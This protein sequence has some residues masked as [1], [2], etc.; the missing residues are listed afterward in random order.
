LACNQ[1]RAISALFSAKASQGGFF[2]FWL[3]AIPSCILKYAAQQKATVPAFSLARPSG[4][5][6]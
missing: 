3:P 1:I 4:T 2:V 6:N 5:G